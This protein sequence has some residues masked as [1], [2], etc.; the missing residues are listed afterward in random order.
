M[1]RIRRIHDDLLPSNR[2]A[3]EQVQAILAD[4]IPAAGV[5]AGTALNAQLLNPLS[6]QLR[7]LLWVAEDGK[8]RVQ[9]FAY[10]L[11]APD[12]GLAWLDWISASR[13][14]RSGVGGALYD[15]VREAAL[16]LDVP[17]IFL[18]CLPDDPELCADPDERAENGRRLKFYEGYGARPIIG[19]KWETPV[20][21]GDDTP[22]LLVFDDLGQDLPLPAAKA[23][24]LVRAILERKYASLCPPDYME[25]VIGSFVDDPIQLR[26][27]RYVKTERVNVPRKP[28]P[29]DR[30]IALFAHDGHEIHHVRERGYVETPT[31][32]R[33]IARELE[34]TL[35][36]DSQPI[37]RAPEAAITAVHDAEMVSYFKKLCAS[38]PP[39]RSVYPYVFPVRNPYRKPRDL[40]T[41]VGYY[42]I[43]TFT[44]M[45]RNAWTA[46]RR[47]ADC[48][49]SAALQVSRGSQL[50]Y[51][52]VRPPGHHAERSA[53]GG[54][55]YLNN[56]AIAAH[57]LSRIGPVAL[58]D[59][60]YHH[61]NGQQDIFWSRSDVLTVSIHGHPSFAY[62]Y[63]CGFAD[64]VGSGPGEGY[65]LN[66]P[67]PETIEV[68]RFVDALDKAVRRIR[69]FEPMFLVVSLGLDTARRDPTGTWPL[70]A[71]DF[72]AM[73]AVIGGQGYPTVVVQ[74]GGYD[75][76]VLG[77][78]ARHF[79]TGLF[80]GAGAD[81]R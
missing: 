7:A 30:Q 48:A 38:L 29:V 77:V 24:V 12:I 49:Y 80:R 19:T 22:P 74:E 59:I 20:P 64:E 75:T 60:D 18:E 26:P 37:T 35:L 36:F 53:F 25:M 41:R 2:E 11:H 62:P 68:R 70:R 55:C 28:V 3:V 15:R 58:L 51:A 73:G 23:R 33:A 1:F 79:F 27:P 54:F 39:E 9:G 50:A 31:R 17:G 57:E 44:P 61:G 40:E 10:L 71:K 46:A 4:R 47:A 66:L 5:S 65:N 69:R 45:S 72:D 67:L 42:C 14:A 78:N 76:R 13:G 16:G 6:Q 34:K 8:G 63:F 81:K 56:A 52:L 43:D 21:S 32:I